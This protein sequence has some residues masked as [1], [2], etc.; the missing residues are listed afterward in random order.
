[1]RRTVEKLVSPVV[2]SN[3]CLLCMWRKHCSMWKE[4]DFPG[5]FLTETL[6]AQPGVA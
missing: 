5:T 2:Q 3:Q 4:L 6:N 1:M